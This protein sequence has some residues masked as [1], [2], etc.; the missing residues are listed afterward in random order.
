MSLLDEIESSGDDIGAG[1]NFDGDYAGAPPFSPRTLS[2]LRSEMIASGAPRSFAWTC[3]SRV[4]LLERGAAL[5]GGQV[6][7]HA[8]A[9]A[10]WHAATWTQPATLAQTRANR[11]HVRRAIE[12]WCGEAGQS[13]ADTG[14]TIDISIDFNV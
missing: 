5:T 7:E 3:A 11:A 9:I 13:G 8:R 2:E 10:D 6:R 14:V 12:A 1:T 4:V